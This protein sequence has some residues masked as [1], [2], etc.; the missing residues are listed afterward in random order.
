LLHTF[1]EAVP[2]VVYAKDRDGCLL[3]ANRG[4]TELIGKP[5][6]EYLGRTDSEFL[7]KAQ[8]EAIMANDRR[9]MESGVT[10]QVEET[11]RL[12]DGTPAT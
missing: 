7:D 5:P 3:M 8:G 6:E 1:I 11:V 9:I 4:T 2:G 12:P 10:Q